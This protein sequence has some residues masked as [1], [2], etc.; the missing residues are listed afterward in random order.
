MASCSLGQ[1]SSRGRGRPPHPTWGAEPREGSALPPGPPLLPR[2]PDHHHQP[3]QVTKMTTL[4][5]QWGGD[6][7][8]HMVATHPA[9]ALAPASSGSWLG[10]T[11]E[12]PIGEGHLKTSAAHVERGGF[13]AHHG[14]TTPGDPILHPLGSPQ[15]VSL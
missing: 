7:C 14:G 3:F 11:A 5:T 1:Q 2:G 4:V 9:S 10:S 13:R 6:R 15:L 8:P 12:Q